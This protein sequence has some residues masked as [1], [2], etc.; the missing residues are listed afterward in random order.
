MVSWGVSLDRPLKFRSA[1]P[2]SDTQTR[3]VVRG[4]LD[5]R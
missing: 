4:N 2:E 5:L 1:R 3:A